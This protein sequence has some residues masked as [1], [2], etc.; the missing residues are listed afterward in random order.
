M[1]LS[2]RETHFDD[3]YYLQYSEVCVLYHFEVNAVNKYFWLL[4]V[5]L[6]DFLFLVQFGMLI[7]YLFEKFPNSEDA[8]ETA[9][10][11]LQVSEN[12]YFLFLN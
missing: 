7:E 9:I 2:F 8:N 6:K 1:A 11:E 4:I 5:F 10:G 3:L 12:F